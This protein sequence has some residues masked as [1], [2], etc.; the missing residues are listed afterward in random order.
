[1]KEELLQ[2]LDT[3]A[4]KLGVTIEYLW[5]IFVR[6][7]VLEAVQCCFLFAA[8][9]ALALF[10]IRKIVATSK[11][12]NMDDA[13]RFGYSILYGLVAATAFLISGAAFYNMG[14]F[15]NPEFYALQ[16]LAEMLK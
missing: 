16:E 12:R 7:Q 15:F 6:Q 4:A 9:V 14:G 11:R 8:M 10:C 3:L 1:M 13:D 5:P 2:R